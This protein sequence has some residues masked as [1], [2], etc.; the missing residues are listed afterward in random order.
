MFSN[1]LMNFMGNSSVSFLLKHTPS[2]FPFRDSNTLTT[3]Q[4]EI[5]K[6]AKAGH[7]IL[8]TGQA[9]TGKSTLVRDLQKDLHRQGRK[10]AIVCSSGITG[11]VHL[12]DGTTAL[13]AHT[14]YG[15]HTW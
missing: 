13:T 12:R 5:I 11:T 8:V 1:F 4:S 6:V 3:E 15:L 10:V 7:N 9:G 14:F 2:S